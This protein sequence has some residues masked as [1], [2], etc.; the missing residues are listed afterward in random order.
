M[1]GQMLDLPLAQSWAEAIAALG[2]AGALG[3]AARVYV[4][5][6][7][8]RR[9]DEATQARLVHREP[10][11]DALSDGSIDFWELQFFVHNDSSAAIHNLAA[12]R[13]KR[14]GTWQPAPDEHLVAAAERINARGNAPIYL[15]R[16]ERSPELAEWEIEFEFT[17]AHGRRWRRRGIEQPTRVTI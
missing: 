14:E 15:E 6:Q 13:V 9:D 16:L 12:V 5:S 10:T 3:V 4:L 1:S 7:R 8:D 2:T 17:D 11:L